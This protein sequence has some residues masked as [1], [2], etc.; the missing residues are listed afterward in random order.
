MKLFGRNIER[1]AVVA[2]VLAFAVGCGVGCS[3][4]G[5]E[6]SGTKKATEAPSKER[7][8]PKWAPTSDDSASRNTCEGRPAVKLDIGPVDDAYFEPGHVDLPNPCPEG[9]LS[10]CLWFESEDGKKGRYG[11]VCA[12][13]GKHDHPICLWNAGKWDCHDE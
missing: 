10:M 11:A 13:A 9:M 12:G 2:A 6:P 7:R 3:R 4:E 1:Q 5:S 8:R